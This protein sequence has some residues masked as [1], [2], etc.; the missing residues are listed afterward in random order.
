MVAAAL[1]WWRSW[2]RRGQGNRQSCWQI[3]GLS[4]L[5]RFDHIDCLW[6]LLPLNAKLLPELCFEGKMHQSVDCWQLPFG[7]KMRLSCDDLNFCPFSEMNIQMHFFLLFCSFSINL[8]SRTIGLSI[9]STLGH[10]Q[11]FDQWQE[12]LWSG[13]AN[14][15][16]TT[17]SWGEIKTR[18]WL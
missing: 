7:L 8:H 9:T 11:E 15:V 4:T 18:H 13:I 10:F 12:K 16:K 3:Q 5:M 17:P 14:V 1:M 6:W 2:R